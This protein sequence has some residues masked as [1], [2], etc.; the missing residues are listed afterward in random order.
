MTTFA[1]TM[2]VIRVE[3]YDHTTKGH[4]VKVTALAPTREQARESDIRI[5][6]EIFHLSLLTAPKLGDLIPYT[7]G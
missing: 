5:E 7:V 2:R 3:E 1:G 6:V 4:C